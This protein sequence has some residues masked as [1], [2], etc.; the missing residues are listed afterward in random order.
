MQLKIEINNLA[1]S[2][3]E[4]KMLKKIAKLAVEKSGYAFLRNKTVSLSF[5]WVNEMEIKKIN[6]TYRCKNKATNVLSFCEYEKLAE[7]KKNPEKEI[8]LGEIIL[9][10]NFI[11]AMVRKNSIH[12][13]GA[14]E[15]ELAKIIAHGVLHLL[16]FEHGKKMF[17]IQ[18]ACS[19]Q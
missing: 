10:Y 12:E 13:D 14:M 18:D 5:A 7:L 9:C 2:P 15:Q 6:H 19:E 16:C 1:K 11:E 3:V 17:S 4:K 8:F